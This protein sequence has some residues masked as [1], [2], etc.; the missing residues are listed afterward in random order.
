MAVAR[1]VSNLAMICL[2]SQALREATG[3][4]GNQV[5]GPALQSQSAQR[6]PVRSRVSLE[7]ECEELARNVRN[8]LIVRAMSGR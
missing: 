8:A 2:V 3:K 6:Q 5:A 4:Q 1:N 7:A